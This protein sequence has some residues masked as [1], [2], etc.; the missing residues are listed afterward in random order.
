MR[1]FE[2]DAN[3]DL[4]LNSA[5]NLNMLTSAQAIAQNT[6][7]AVSAMRGEMQYAVTS[8]LPARATAFDRLNTV[9][10]EVAVRAVILTVQGVLSVD[11]FTV[12][13]NN[14]TLQYTATILTTE[15]TIDV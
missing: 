7:T 3:N 1:T 4:V 2:I 6:R 8:G 15:G 13:N 11:R 12:V 5:G 14:G 9:Q 10:F